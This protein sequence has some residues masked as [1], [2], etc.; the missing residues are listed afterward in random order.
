MIVLNLLKFKYDIKTIAETILMI[1][2]LSVLVP[3]LWI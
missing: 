1:T 3:V 2:T